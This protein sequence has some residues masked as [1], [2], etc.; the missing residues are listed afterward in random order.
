MRKKPAK[1]KTATRS[2]R[3][4]YNAQWAV[5]F[6]HSLGWTPCWIGTGH[7]WRD[8]CRKMRE[9][10][11]GCPSFKYRVARIEIREIPA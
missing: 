5:L 7:N 10:K 4:A 9:A 3:L 8:A 6:L 1:M 2:K 11:T